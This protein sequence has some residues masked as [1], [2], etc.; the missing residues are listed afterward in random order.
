MLK[1]FFTKRY[2]CFYAPPLIM[3]LKTYTTAIHRKKGPEKSKVTVFF[4][5]TCFALFRK[6]PRNT[7]PEERK[8]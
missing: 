6:Y 2:F 8:S 7:L 1:D 3:A 5:Q 4:T